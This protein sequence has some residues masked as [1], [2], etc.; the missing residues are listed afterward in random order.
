MLIA[1]WGS[2]EEFAEL[3]VAGC[4]VSLSSAL[5]FL[6]DFCSTMCRQEERV[7][8]IKILKGKGRALL[9]IASQRLLQAVLN[10]VS[11]LIAYV[12]CL[13]DRDRDLPSPRICGV[14][15]FFPVMIFGSFLAYQELKMDHRPYICISSSGV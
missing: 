9:N 11:L 2:P 5:C 1:L 7:E 12:Q 10:W 3:F 15:T 6:S 14:T 13:A 8:S 4:R